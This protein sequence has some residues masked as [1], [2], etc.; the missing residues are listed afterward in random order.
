[1]PKGHTLTIKYSLVRI[2]TPCYFAQDSAAA[3]RTEE[4]RS[5]PGEVLRLL[6]AKEGS[7]EWNDPMARAWRGYHGVLAFHGVC[8]A[9]ELMV[10][11][12]EVPELEQLVTH[13]G[14]AE[15]LGAMGAPDWWQGKFHLMQRSAL[16]RAD[17]HH[18]QALWP[19]DPADLPMIYPGVENEAFRSS[20]ELVNLKAE[21]DRAREAA[22]ALQGRYEEALRR[23]TSDAKAK[24]QEARREQR[25]GRNGWDKERAGGRV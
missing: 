24:A 11:G 21:L 8:F 1:M 22:N 16:L 20:R 9:T 25:F 12:E 2:W 18:Y 6:D 23:A 3:L 14:L 17:A 7:L 4:L 15:S 19:D 10:R 13:Y 5:Q